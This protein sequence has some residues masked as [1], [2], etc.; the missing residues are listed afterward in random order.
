MTKFG[1][2]C[3]VLGI[4]LA[5]GA[6]MNQYCTTAGNITKGGVPCDTPGLYTKYNDCATKSTRPP[7]SCV[8]SRQRCKA[9]ESV[10]SAQCKSG[11]GGAACTDTV[12]CVLTNNDT[13]AG[14]CTQ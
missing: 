2:F 3:Y 6:G 8:Q 12:N 14:E 10:N 11:E 9:A 4:V 1:K 13:T 5:I 7:G